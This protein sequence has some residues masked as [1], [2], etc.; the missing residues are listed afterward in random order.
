[1]AYIKTCNA[2]VSIIIPVYNGADTIRYCLNSVCMQTYPNLEIILVDDASTDATSMVLN[3]YRLN[4]RR[5]KV[6]FN[7]QNKGVSYSRNLALDKTAGEYV[8]F[9]DS[10]DYIYMDMVEHCLSF[11]GNA[12]MIVSRLR[13]VRNDEEFIEG[14]NEDTDISKPA[15]WDDIAVNKEIYGMIGGKF[16]RRDAIGDIRF[17]VGMSFQEDLDFNMKVYERC[18]V[19]RKS[20]YVGYVYQKSDKKKA[21]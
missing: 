4:D 1:M 11:I 21:I 9:V 13:A 7:R 8:M 10:D 17:N 16:Y 15:I 20:S 3:T 14:F 2:L 5:I 6:L 18:G 12:D 19:V